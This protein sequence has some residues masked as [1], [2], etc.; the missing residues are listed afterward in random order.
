VKPNFNRISRHYTE[1]RGA[2]LQ[3]G[4]HKW[5][6]DPYA[7]EFMA[8]VRMTPIERALWSDARAIGIVLY[9]QYP[10]GRYFVDFANP[11]ARV[12]IECDGAAYHADEE[13]DQRRQAAIEAL[14]WTVYRFTGRECYRTES[15][16]EDEHGRERFQPCPM[17]ADL[18]AIAE[19]HGMFIG[20]EVAPW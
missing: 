10:V 8:G 1:H 6:L 3:A 4:A 7:W 19:Q 16:T 14:G 17:S 11:A 2:I 18:R 5:G 20:S 15:T 9:P 13:R 12:A